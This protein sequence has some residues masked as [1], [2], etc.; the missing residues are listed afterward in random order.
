MPNTRHATHRGLAACLNCCLY[1]GL[2]VKASLP[3]EDKTEPL[4]L[5]LCEPGE[6][7]EEGGQLLVGGQSRH[8]P[9]N[10]GQSLLGHQVLGEGDQDSV[11]T[12]SLAWQAK[13]PE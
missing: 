7:G 9:G 13:G 11:L 5:S 8:I 3:T 1:D 2:H 10:K 12:L 4:V 6:E